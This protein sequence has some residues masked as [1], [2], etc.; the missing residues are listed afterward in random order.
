MKIIFFIF[1][2]II[3]IFQVVPKVNMKLRLESPI[4]FGQNEISLDSISSICE[5]QEKNVFVLD[6]KAYKVY[7]FSV[8]GKYLLSFG[9]RGQGPGD[10]VM[11]HTIQIS[12]D[13][14]L[15]VNEQRDFASI[16]NTDGKFLE[17]IKV[18]K[19]LGVYFID[20]NLFY[21][22]TWEKKHKQQ[23]LI[24][25]KGNI[26]NSFFSIDFD[27]FSISLPDETGRLV[28]FNYYAEEYTPFF[29][30][31]HYKKYSAIGISDKYE[32]FIIQN[33]GKV[34]S[35]IINNIKPYEISKN[36]K[37]YF[38]DAINNY[39][40]FP[41]QVKKR[42]IKRIPGYKNFFNN[43]L[44]SDQYVWI[45]RIKKD[46]TKEN[47]GISVDLYTYDSK[48]KG[49]LI[50]KEAPIFISDKNIYFV[51]TNQNEDLFLIRYKYFIEKDFTNM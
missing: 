6:A 40:K 11:P 19:G 24:N 22:W 7:K 35:K 29:V 45:F 17:R 49:T 48:F 26:I 30:F 46:I 39:Y 18:K 34:V 42:F 50:I 25:E 37:N 47:T 31:S 36:E 8:E 43:I 1:V 38:K 33:D 41:K 9:N 20:Y 21:C 32:I 5:S 2:F 13:G 27:K 28:M 51:R 23:L 10:F 12:T 16:F 14:N 4:S 44:L 15:V 3:G